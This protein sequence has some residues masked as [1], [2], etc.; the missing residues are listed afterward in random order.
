AFPERESTLRPPSRD[1]R[2]ERRRL[3]GR[4]RGPGHA[5]PARASPALPKHRAARAVVGALRESRPGVHRSVRGSLSAVRSWLPSTLGLVKTV[6][7][8]GVHYYALIVN[9]VPV[10]IL[11]ASGYAGRE[12]SALI[13]RHPRLE[14]AF[15]TA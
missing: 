14:L 7:S 2:T 11:G 13:L 10:G 3:R 12:L 4:E 9:K 8:E 15:A 1:A 6:D 5:G